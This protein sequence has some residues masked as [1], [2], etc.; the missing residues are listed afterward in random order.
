[1]VEEGVG[2]IDKIFRLP[3]INPFGLLFDC[4]RQFTSAEAWDWY[5]RGC[6]DEAVFIE[7]MLTKISRDMP[8]EVRWVT[9]E[10]LNA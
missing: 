7:G 10:E 9:D 3:N 2:M 4:Y 5:L 8:N 1:M 6:P